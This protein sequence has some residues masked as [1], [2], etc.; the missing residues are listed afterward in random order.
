M[1]KISTT[2]IDVGFDT[3]DTAFHIAD[4]HIRNLKRHTE[5]RQAF[6]KLYSQL[7]RRAKGTNS[8]I[9]VLGDIVHAKL[10]MSP[11]LIDMVSDLFTNLADIAPTIVIMGNHDCNLNNK[12]RLDALSPIIANIDHKDLHYFKDGG[13]YEV[14]DCKIAVMSVFEPKSKYLH[15]HDIDG[16]TKIAMYHGV[17][18]SPKSDLGFFLPSHLNIETFNGYDIVMLGDIHKHQF[19]DKDHRIG[20]V[21]S[22]IQQNH[23]EDLEKG[24]LQW[25]IPKREAKFVR[26]NNDYGYYTLDIK[27]GKIPAVD[28]M[29]RKPRL[30]IK[31]TNTDVS[32]VKRILADVRKIYKVQDVAV[33]RDS[34]SDQKTGDRNLVSKLGDIRNPQLQNEL[35]KDYLDRNFALSD[36]LLSQIYMINNNINTRLPELEVSRNITW[37]PKRFE[38]SNMFSYGEGNVVDFSKLRETVGLFASNASGKSALLDALTFCIYDKCSRTFKASNVINNKEKTFKC[39]FNFEVGGTDYFIERVATTVSKGFFEGHVRVDVNFWMIDESG[40][41]ISLNGEQRRET[42]KNIRGYIGDY[43]DFMLT[44]LSIQGNNTGYIECSQSEKKDLLAQFL[45]INVF[46]EL[47]SVAS[48]EIKDVAALLKEFEQT[49]FTTELAEIEDNIKQY[50]AEYR[51]KNKTRRELTKKKEEI[52]EKIN[53]LNKKLVKINT[54]VQNIDKLLKQK[55][56]VKSFIDSAGDQRFELEEKS[57]KIQEQMD[58]INSK[59]S[60][61]DVIELEKKYEKLVEAEH[62]RDSFQ[63]EIEKI[64]VDVKHKL[65]KLKMLE[66]HKYDPDCEYCMNNPFVI[67]AIE[68]RKAI[69]D[70]KENAQKFATKLNETKDI[71]ER[72]LPVR[73][74]YQQFQDLE[75]DFS[76][77]KQNSILINSERS[78][79]I[80]RRDSLENELKNI[81]KKIEAYY[82]QEEDIKS[83]KQ[84]QEEID[85]VSVD[86]NEV[87]REL[88]TVVKELQDIHGNQKVSETRR[89]DIITSMDKAKTLEQK[90]KAYEYY[91]DAIKRDGVPYELISR[92][93]PSIESEVNNILNQIVDF[94]I[95]FEVDGKNINNLI[96]Y[97]EQNIWPLELTSGM[98]KFI[99]SLAIR[100]ALINISS[101]PRPN[102]LA[103]DEGFGTLDAENLN[104]IFMLFEYMKSQFDFLLVISHLDTMRDI[105]GTLLEIKREKDYSYIKFA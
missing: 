34:L 53:K 1:T 15:A 85:K 61:F 58:K 14:A 8:V 9:C 64:K 30:R 99:S 84:V 3:L 76:S 60:T 25:D 29:P 92:I 36:D 78:E 43:D 80:R 94:N 46:E 90:Y 105:V 32:D 59:L 18:G 44:A 38:F 57:G 67:D 81:K 10:D 37:K 24:F 79:N 41:K 6:R 91:L 19:L 95:V 13:V 69:F 7:K 40:T 26:L 77:L 2:K 66:Q 42:N 86:F 68:T 35:I 17:V 12:A 75:Q 72:L 100:T 93:I 47:H 70:D 4:V 96:V 45:D 54:T 52:Q 98:E 20:Y 49:D 104:S 5:Y 39:L 11:E 97:D 31:I 55:K 74:E 50:K 65:E 33:L 101:L 73:N 21:G 63:S 56:D 71:V 103:I 82:Q 87:D 83:N 16:K 27:D 102:F 22:L 88:N 23:G 51:Q 48:E 28:N 89:D 62:D